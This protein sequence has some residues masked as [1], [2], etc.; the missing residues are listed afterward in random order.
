MTLPLLDLSYMHAELE[1]ELDEAWQQVSR[2]A[3]F[4]G[5]EFVERF[6]NQWADY[7]NTSH[8]V[9]VS[10]GTAALQLALAA[11]GIGPGD[12]VIVPTNT[13]F[14][15]VDAV[16]AVGAA[17]VFVDVDPETLLMTAAGVESATT[18][19]SAAVIAVH[20]YGQPVD[21]D[22]INRVSSAAGLA[23]IEDAAQAHGATWREKKAGSL[24]NIGCFSFY[25]GKNLGAFGGAGAILGISLIQTGCDCGY[26]GRRLRD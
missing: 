7:C 6:E 21:M 17:P 1:N 3:K 15:T 24:G 5:G 11:L 12:E 9:G 14:G 20:L 16:L 22:S 8:C 19:R 4:I 13:F 18:R 25:P 2:S 26:L 10:S 23:V